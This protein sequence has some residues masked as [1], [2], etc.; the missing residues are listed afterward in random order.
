[1]SVTLKP[2]AR[3]A[4]LGA[5]GVSVGAFGLYVLIAYFSRATTLGGIDATQAWLTWISL[6][7]PVAAVIGAHV[8]YARILLRYAREA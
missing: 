2:Y 3:L 4:A 6:A 1:M 8:V 7:V 5:L